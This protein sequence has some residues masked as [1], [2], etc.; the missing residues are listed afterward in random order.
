MHNTVEFKGGV[1]DHCFL[2][3]RKLNRGKP[4]AS[5]RQPGVAIFASKKV[6]QLKNRSVQ[7]TLRNLHLSHLEKKMKKKIIV[8]PN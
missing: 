6:V 1:K 4:V 7:T 2:P 5:S 3:S 8:L